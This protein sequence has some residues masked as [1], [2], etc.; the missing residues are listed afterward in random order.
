MSFANAGRIEKRHRQSAKVEMNFD[1]VTRRPGIGVK[2][3]LPLVWQF[4]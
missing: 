4:D 1:N 2:R 3:L